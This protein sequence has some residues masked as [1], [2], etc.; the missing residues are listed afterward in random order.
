[1]EQRQ[2][3]QAEDENDLLGRVRDRRERVRA[4]HR[5]GEAL[6]QQRLAQTICAERLAEQYAGH[7]GVRGHTIGSSG[8]GLPR[9]K[10]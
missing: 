7:A 4:E 10:S 8:H 6:R 9:C 2:A 5:Q 3:T 1:M